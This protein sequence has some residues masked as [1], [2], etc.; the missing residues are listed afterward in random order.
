MAGI[1]IVTTHPKREEINR[2]L[3]R[4]ERLA[5]IAAR[6]LPDRSPRAGEE[7]LRRWRKSSLQVTRSAIEEAHAHKET[8]TF[9]D[10]TME[11]AR[12]T[13]AYRQEAYAKGRWRDVD[14]M[15]G[16]L[17]D[18]LD[19]AGRAIGAFDKGKEEQ[20]EQVNG[21]SVN[22]ANLIAA[23][24]TGPL[25]EGQQPRNNV[26]VSYLRQIGA[27]LDEDDED[28]EDV[29]DAEVMESAGS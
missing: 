27:I 20:P 21:V 5:N 28:S 15:S 19:V 7:V 12:E 13:L 16:H 10:L 14:K 17:T 25:I 22:I 1:S 3:L 26:S 29:E 6:F 4:G 11:V 23:P 24:N 18:H 8:E 9:E 2:A